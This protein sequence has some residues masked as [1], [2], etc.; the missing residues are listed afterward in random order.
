MVID[1][2]RTYE[3]HLI[4]ER[5][6]RK[7]R[8]RRFW[9]AGINDLFAIDQH[10]KWKRFGLC[11]HAGIDPFPGKIHWVKIWWTNSNP[12]LICSYYLETIKRTGCEWHS[13]L[14]L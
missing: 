7:L 14:S 2:F 5:A 10:D 9:A 6:A 13:T 12:K 1:Y 8:R 4:R 3:P 11:L